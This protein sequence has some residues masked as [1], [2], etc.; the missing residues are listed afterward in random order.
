MSTPADRTEWFRV[1]GQNIKG[2]PAM[3]AWQV[4]HDL[5]EVQA[6][7]HLVM[8]QEF[9][10]P[11]YWRAARRVLGRARKARQR[12]GSTPDWGKGVAQPVLG[13]QAVMWR[14]SRFSLERTKV[15]LAHAGVAKVSESRWWR[16]ALLKVD[17]T[18]LCL[19]A[20]SGHCVV[21]GDQDG[22]SQRRKDLLAGDLESLD[23]FLTEARASGFPG[24]IHFDGNIRPGGWA[25]PELR[26]ILRK[27]GVQLIGPVTGVEYLGV[28]H[29]EGVRVE[30]ESAFQ[31]PTSRLFTDHEGRGGRIRLVSRFPR[32]AGV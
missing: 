22:D 12:W 19:W 9:R 14:L 25:Y 31:V 23:Q 3:K 21:G 1:L 26:R 5:R 18:D 20:V 13:G 16:G 27:H 24:V 17:E 6:N 32:P 10:W 2:T 4:S 29:S 8:V 28:W 7:A 15:A 30:V 11:W